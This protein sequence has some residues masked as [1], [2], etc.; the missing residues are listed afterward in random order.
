MAINL[1][2]HFLL[3]Q[4]TGFLLIFCRIGAALMFMPAFGDH[5]VSP[6]IRLLFGLAFSAVLT[7]LLIDKM[8]ALPS[9]SITLT[10]LL[11]SEILVG[12][13]IGMIGRALMSVLHVTGT[14]IAY[15][16]S[17]AVSSIFD[18]VTGAQT[19]VLSNFL[20]IVAITVMLALNLHHY[21]IA[22]MVES[23]G[24]FTPGGYPLVEDMLKHYTRLISDCFTLGI[25]LSAPHIVFSFIFYLMGGLMARLMPNFQIF[26]VMMSPQIIIALLL[27]FAILPM[28]VEVFVNFAQDQLQYFAGEI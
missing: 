17:L 27:M 12:V 14:M 8:P 26:F 20:T 7:P 25:L 13:F 1:L 24:I 23:Y 11:V 15:Q 18:P 2:D 3:T 28:M 19:A 9:S 22:A 21:M 5:Y 6:R 4:L 16:S 10:L